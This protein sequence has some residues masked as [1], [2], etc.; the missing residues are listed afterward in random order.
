MPQFESSRYNPSPRPISMS[1]STFPR[2][3]KN[4]FESPSQSSTAS[5]SSRFYCHPASHR[6]SG[7]TASDCNYQ[8]QFPCQASPWQNN[9]FRQSILTCGFH[10]SYSPIVLHNCTSI[11]LMATFSTLLLHNSD[12]IKYAM[13]W[14][15]QFRECSLYV[16]MKDN[17]WIWNARISSDKGKPTS[18]EKHMS[19][20]WPWVP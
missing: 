1:L 12:H 3:G 16:Q 2:Y 20:F 6:I 8:V 7:W 17:T 15:I 11:S 4:K 19:N 9:Q 13:F 10:R 5:L 14:V 18:W